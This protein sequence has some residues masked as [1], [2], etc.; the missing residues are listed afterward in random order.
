MI[1]PITA[2]KIKK[3]PFLQKVTFLLGNLTAIQGEKI[4]N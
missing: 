3:T 4:I 1:Y 2:E